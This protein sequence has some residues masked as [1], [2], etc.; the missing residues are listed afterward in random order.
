V[1]K[2]LK[3]GKCVWDLEKGTL[4]YLSGKYII[5]A[6]LGFR[7][8]SVK[9]ISKLYGNPRIFK[10]LNDKVSRQFEKKEGAYWILNRRKVEEIC[11]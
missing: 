1:L 9:E 7:Q 3:D 10:P 2:I 6:T 8:L 11:L 4:L 5:A